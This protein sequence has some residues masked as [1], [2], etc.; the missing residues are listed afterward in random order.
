MTAVI[1]NPPYII[2]TIGLRDGYIPPTFVGYLEI[3]TQVRGRGVGADMLE[4]SRVVRSCQLVTSHS[5]LCLG[6]WMAAP[7]L[8]GV[9]TSGRRRRTQS[10]RGN[11]EG[12]KMHYDGVE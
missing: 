7:M 8:A 1:N 5:Q 9:E 6:V 2:H 11:Q 10:G 4:L 12:G 3:V